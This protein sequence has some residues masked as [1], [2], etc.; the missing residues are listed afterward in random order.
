VNQVRLSGTLCVHV[1]VGATERGAP[2]A[3]G[4]LKFN[5]TDDSVPFFCVCEVAHELARFNLGEEIVITG[6]LVIRGIGNRVA[7]AAD[8]IEPVTLHTPDAR[9]DIEFFHTMRTHEE[10]SQVKGRR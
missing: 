5:P 1:E 6:R 10:N 7:I 2:I 4:R 8:R 9:R 3:K